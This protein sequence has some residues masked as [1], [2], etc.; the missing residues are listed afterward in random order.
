MNFPPKGPLQWFA[1]GGQTKAKK[2]TDTVF[3]MAIGAIKA[4]NRSQAQA[5]SFFPWQ[6]SPSSC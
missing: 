1:Q 4:N 5:R 2:Q 3:T 6:K